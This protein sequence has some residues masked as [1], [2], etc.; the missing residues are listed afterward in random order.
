MAI[1]Q[2]HGLPLVEDN[3]HALGGALDGKKLGTFGELAIQSFHDTKNIHS[4]EGGALLINDS[5]LVERAEMIREKGTNRSRFLRG[6][7]DKYTWSD[8]GSSYL[9]SELNAAIL[10]SQLAE[11]EHI[12]S[13]RHDI[14][15]AYKEHLGD[16]ARAANVSLMSP[17]ARTSHTA[18]MFYM[19][20]P[21][22]DAQSRFLSHMRERDIVA[23]FHFVPLDSS[24]AGLRLGYTP[25]PCTNSTEFSERL[26]RLP[27]WAGMTGSDV[28]RVIDAATSFH[29]GE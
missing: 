21:S 15:S 29:T 13:L 18:H 7:V 24:T 14:W 4:G 5:A 23:T 26:V 22:H 6:Q 1:A 17:G 20:M 3:A 19:L 11:F 27:L 25:E 16:W 28:N 9:P 8:I 10:D 12:Q 2:K